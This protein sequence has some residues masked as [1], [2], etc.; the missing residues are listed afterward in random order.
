MK[1][2]LK[3]VC[4]FIVLA[5]F[6]TDTISGQLSKKSVATGT[7]IE[8]N[9]SSSSTRIRLNDGRIHEGEMI[10]AGEYY[11]TVS[12]LSDLPGNTINKATAGHEVFVEGFNGAPRAGE[13][14]KVLSN[15][16][17]IN[18]YF[19]IEALL[20]FYLFYLVFQQMNRWR[21]IAL[22]AMLVITLSWLIRNVYLGKFY[23]FDSTTNGIETIII[24]L[25]SIVF[26][27]FQLIRPQTNFIYSTPA[28]WIISAILVYKAGTFFLFLY[29]N[30]LE[31][32][33]RE[34]FANLYIINSFFQVLKNILIMVAFLIARPAKLR[35]L[36]QLNPAFK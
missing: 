13:N 28:F 33:E 36:S 30:T 32:Y 23:S 15:L 31:K 5:S 22:L 35:K 6:L 3:W 27:Y 16:W 10:I 18:I 1:D 12:K 25:F 11:G 29:F 8:S 34:T 21:N 20:A 14:F 19:L 7:I 24:I 17:V 26:L 4:L 9:S 2:R